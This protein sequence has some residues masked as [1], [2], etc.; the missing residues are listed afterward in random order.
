MMHQNK[1]HAQWDGQSMTP[2]REACDVLIRDAV[3]LTV[4]A[5]DTI[6]ED[7]AIAIRDGLI[8]EVG[9]HSEVTP[10]YDAA[11]MIN[12]NGG[13]VHPGFIDA[14]VHVSQ[15]TSRSVLS[16][17]VGRAATM[18][19]W[20]SLLTP[21]DEHAS[22]AL[23]ALDY[24]R[25]GYTAFVDPGT[26]F[27]PDAVAAACEE[28]GIRAWLTDPYVA[29]LGPALAQKYPEFANARFIARWPRNLDDA[30]HRL[31][32]QLFRNRALRSRVRAFI[33][34]YGEGTDS[35]AL[36]RAAMDI[37]RANGVQ[38]QKHLGYSPTVYR[39]QEQSVGVCMTDHLERL[40]LL[41]PALTLIHMNVVRQPEIALLAERGVRLVWC[42]YGQL[43]MIGRSGAEPRMPELWRAGVSVGIGSDI[44]RAT[45]VA[46]LGTMASACAVASGFAASGTEILRARTMGSAA[47]VGAETEVGS[48]EVGKRADVVVRHANSAEHLALDH[49]LEAGVIA[50]PNSIA[51]VLV[52]GNLVVERGE[53]L[54]GDAASIIARAQESVRRLWSSVSEGP[55]R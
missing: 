39:E 35:D 40:G 52:D 27:E 20:K 7:G 11:R 44:A 14:H 31:G 8:V 9:P 32:S 33:G 47:S 4:D 15:Y 23:A 2:A 55:T 3:I 53:L 48:I 42:P 10:R 24:L 36:F 29:D 6:L 34:L 41:D 13:V 45:H 1:R 21:E 22:A 17:M 43:Q 51:A 49:A 19:D 46:A 12:A 5:Q 54:T 37:A 30:L 38:M 28:L 16:R 50:G 25:S 26:I 18:G